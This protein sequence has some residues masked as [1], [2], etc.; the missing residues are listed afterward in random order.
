MRNSGNTDNI[1]TRLRNSH[2]KIPDNHNSGYEI[3]VSIGSISASITRVGVP[4]LLTHYG[5]VTFYSII[6]LILCNAT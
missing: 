5:I 2:C 4:T 6:C 1:G 3:H